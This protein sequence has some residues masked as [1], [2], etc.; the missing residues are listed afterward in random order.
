MRSFY[1]MRSALQLKK[2]AADA[3]SEF[4]QAGKSV[5]TIDSIEPAGDIVRAWARAAQDATRLREGGPATP[6]PQ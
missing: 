2:G 3:K 1:V 5:A 4:W 6:S